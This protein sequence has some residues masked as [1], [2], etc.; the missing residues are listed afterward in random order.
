MASSAPPRTRP[1]TRSSTAR[2]PATRKA[3]AKRPA[4]RSRARKPAQHR[5]SATGQVVRG[6]TATLTTLWG[7]LAR[8]VGGL[9]RGLTGGAKDLDPD[10]RRDGL[11]QLLLAGAL[12]AA[13]GA[14][15]HA[16]SAGDAVAGLLTEL[17]GKGAMLLPIV[18]ALGAF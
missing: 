12:I 7:L 16:G 8:T 11:G 2:K 5:P 10:H 15:W 9:T 13:G 17:A 14:W 6:L 4:S 3:P 18:L 1:S